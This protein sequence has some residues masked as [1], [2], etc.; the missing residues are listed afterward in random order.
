MPN[1]PDQNETQ[2]LVSVITPSFNQAKYI[3]RTLESVR[4]QTYPRIE[5]IVIDGGSTDGTIEI[6]KHQTFARWISEP[7][8]GQSDALNKGIAR[9]KGD[10]IGWLNSDDMY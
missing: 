3:E 1:S 10:I 8:R 6:L 7:D 2:P 9:A 5:H 4:N